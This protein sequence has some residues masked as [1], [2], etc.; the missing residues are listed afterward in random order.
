MVAMTAGHRDILLRLF[1][2]YE[3]KIVVFPEETEDFSRGDI[4]AFQLAYVKLKK[5]I[6]KMFLSDDV[7]KEKI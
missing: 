5:G 7:K 1:P 4:V 2:E 6:E 3:G